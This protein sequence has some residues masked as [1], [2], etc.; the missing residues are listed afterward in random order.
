MAPGAIGVYSLV[1]KNPPDGGF[2]CYAYWRVY[3]SRKLLCRIVCL[4]HLTYPAASFAKSPACAGTE[5][6]RT[7]LFALLN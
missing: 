3:L 5:A 1:K 6:K 4:L 2:L 7:V